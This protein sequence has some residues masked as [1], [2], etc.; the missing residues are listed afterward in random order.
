MRAVEEAFQKTTQAIFGAPLSGLPEYAEW[1]SSGMP[2]SK[3]FITAD[4]KKPVI[5]PHY[6]VFERLPENRVVSDKWEMKESIGKIPQDFRALA[7]EA[8]KF[9]FF[10]GVVEEGQCLD[11]AES[12]FFVDLNQSYRVLD[13]FYSRLVSCSMISDYSDSIFGCFRTFYSRLVIRCFHSSH[14]SGCFEMDACANCARSMFCHNC[15]NVNDSL[16]CFNTKNKQYAVCNVEVGREEYLRIRK[17]LCDG[18][19]SNLQKGKSLP[20][21]IYS[22]GCPRKPPR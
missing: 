11:N 19:V 10:V 14:L 8:S 4:T 7:K 17:I 20:Y 16:F 12:N 2:Q 1:L 6:S 5:L 15:E 18:I 22:V 3:T 21:G 13:C 9:A